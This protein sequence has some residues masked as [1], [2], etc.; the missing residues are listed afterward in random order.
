MSDLIKKKDVL[1][2][3]KSYIEASAEHMENDGYYEAQFEGLEELQDDLFN[4][5]TFPSADRPQG[6]WME[7]DDV[8]ISCRCSV[9]GWEA[10]LYED[11]IYGMPY[12]PNCGAHMKGTDD[13]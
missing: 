10:H 12:C 11:D 1:A 2:L 7:V 6:E 4:L 13:E 9:C 3:V 5:E 8:S